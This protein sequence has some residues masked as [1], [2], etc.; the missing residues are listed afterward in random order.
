VE[1]S[2]EGTQA[3]RDAALANVT[4]QFNRHGRGLSSWRARKQGLEDGAVSE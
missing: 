4:D 2:F 1:E 3:H